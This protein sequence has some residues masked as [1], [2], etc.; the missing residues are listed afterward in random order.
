MVV[1]HY[2]FNL[3]FPTTYDMDYV[4]LCPLAIHIFSLW[5]V[6]S[7][8]LPSFW[9]LIFL[10]LSWE[11]FTHSGANTYVIGKYFLL[12]CILS[13]HFLNGVFC[14]PRA[15]NFNEVQFI[16]SFFCDFGDLFV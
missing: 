6:Y 1:L 11:F 15:F 10:L 9:V 2:G 3:Y 5:S 8:T 7:N 13:F 14:R 16:F 12:V 4:F